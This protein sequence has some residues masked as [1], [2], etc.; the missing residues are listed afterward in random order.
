MGE[1]GDARLQERRTEGHDES[2]REQ[3]ITV[4]ADRGRPSPLL[5]SWFTV[6][7]N[8]NHNNAVGHQGGQML[9]AAG[10]NRRSYSPRGHGQ[11]RC[12]NLLDVRTHGLSLTLLEAQARPP[13]CRP[14]DRP[15]LSSKMLRCA[16]AVTFAQTLC[17]S[18]NVSRH[19]S[20]M[21]RIVQAF[22]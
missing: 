7:L 10:K 21:V 17:R 9:S 4:R 1:V 2:D 19:V 14:N 20:K 13:F 16:D 5:R 6:H 15:K 12:P 18:A 11:L 8:A 22:L 3:N